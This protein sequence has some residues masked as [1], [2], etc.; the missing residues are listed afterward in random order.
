MADSRE[1]PFSMA[2]VV[3]SVFVFLGVEMTIGGWLAPL[4]I[5]RYV[6]PM[7]HFELQLLA[8]LFSF[9]LGG[10]GVGVLSPGRRL[11]EPAVGA[12]VSVLLVSMIS[13][14]MP[15]IFFAFNVMKVILAGAI[16]FVIALWG[17][18][19]GERAMGNVDPDDPQAS[20]TAR[21]RLRSSLWS[22]KA[23]FLNRGRE[24]E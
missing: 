14:F 7:F 20:Q 11:I 1:R 4:V 24:R 13:L 3:I 9:Y 6:S 8:H 5:G 17:A 15:T 21:G 10:L 19:H 18:W 22:E 23:G 2:W 16:A 12:V